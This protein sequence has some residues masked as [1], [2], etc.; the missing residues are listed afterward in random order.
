MTR[1]IGGGRHLGGPRLPDG[2]LSAWRGVAEGSDLSFECTG[3]F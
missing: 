2:R 3:S 1:T